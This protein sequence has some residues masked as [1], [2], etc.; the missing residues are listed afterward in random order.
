M[1]LN[2]YLYKVEPIQFIAFFIALAITFIL[3]PVIQSRALKLGF[4]DAP[5]VR[6]LHKTPIPRLG[7]VG[8][9]SSLFFTSLILLPV[10]L[11]YSIT[12][13]SSFTLIGIFSGGTIIFFIGLLDDLDPLPAK[14]KLLIQ[15]L[16]ATIAW[17]LGVRIMS[18]SNPFYHSD[19]SI[20]KLSVGDQAY[21]FSPIF[22]YLITVIWIVGITN[23]INL[24]D[25]MDGLAT[26]V[27]IV[28]ALAIWAVSLDYRISQP[29]GALLAATIAGS[30]L[31]FLRWNFNPARIF[32]GDSGAYLIGFILACLT[33]GCATK[34]VAIAVITPLMLLIF[35]LPITDTVLA[36]IRRLAS[37]KPIMQ[38]DK[39][40]LHHKL[41]D[42]G[43]SQKI[44]SYVLY[45]ISF[46]FGI[47]ATSLISK[48]SFLRFTFLSV[49]I[50]I[51][52]LFYA[53]VINWKRQKIFREKE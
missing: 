37:G 34:K 44:T 3:T 8:I 41:L 40:H 26:G 53:L 9:Y 20:F 21:L 31:G 32:L 11:N 12:S 45:F 39:E 17:Y 27:C 15:F 18:I 28:G 16:A 22:S 7:G 6:K 48:S 52:S 42:L 51:L 24:I 47:I 46:T 38:P 10:Y 50:M 36:I 25:G 19:F 2:N 13:Y 1:L 4:L 30:L 43:F 49:F 33:V 5:S 14:I 35:A 23:A 29:E